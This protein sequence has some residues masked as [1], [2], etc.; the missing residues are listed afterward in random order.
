MN[1]NQP[2][3]IVVMELLRLPVNRISSLLSIVL[4]AGVMAGCQESGP[5]LRVEK[6]AGDAVKSAGNGSGESLQGVKPLSENIKIVTGEPAIKS[7]EDAGDKAA[8]DKTGAVAVKM[9]Y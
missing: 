5:N 6:K 7:E 8:K 4:L 2:Q 9:E 3:A 1:Q